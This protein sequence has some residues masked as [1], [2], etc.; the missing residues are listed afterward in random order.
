M[1]RSFRKR[2]G[3]LVS[4]IQRPIGQFSIVLLFG[5]LSLTSGQIAIAAVDAS[6]KIFVFRGKIQSVD[7]AARTFTLQMN[8]GSYVFVITNQTRIVRNG[9]TRQFADLK[10]GQPAEV[11]MK[12]GPGGKGLAVSIQLGISSR[13][14][15]SSV[16]ASQFQSLFAATSPG[17]KTITWPELGR[18]VVQ[19]PVFPI[20]PGI[21]SGPF[22]I[23]VFLLSVRPDGTVSN[24]EMLNST[25]YDKLDKRAA[26]WALVWRF[27]SN[28][29]V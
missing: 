23:A 10:Q 12:I 15:S 26:K 21:E 29:V 11:E 14:S 17:G 27:R 1:A 18:L 6:N 13:E 19:W 22:K 28:I 8:E 4:S 3:N 2:F 9:Q 16:R 25:G 20:L 5:V 24:V 7:A